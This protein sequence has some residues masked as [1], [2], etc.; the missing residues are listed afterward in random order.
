MIP[1]RLAITVVVLLLATAALGGYV[2][3]L[4]HSAEKSPATSVD[5]RPVAPP[6][7]GSTTAVTFFLANDSDGALHQRTVN[8]A[9]P[10]EPSKRGLEIL[11]A[12]V[13]QYLK[14]DSTHPLG[15]SSDISDV[16]VLN[17]IAVIDTNAAF[18][19]G[20]RS[21]ILVEQLTLASLA[22][23]LAAN[24]PGITAIKLLVDGQERPTLAGHADLSA[25]YEVANAAPLVK[26]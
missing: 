7:A 19:D 2:L 13:G 9:L 20:H 15:A 16:Y 10:D 25:P 3:H 23:T 1:R 21:G 12:L 18:G 24:L 4:K 14:P 5:T 11:R 8:I 6:V 26:E 17:N 22:K